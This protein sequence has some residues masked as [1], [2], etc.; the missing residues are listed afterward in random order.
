MD[1]E[2]GKQMILWSFVPRMASSFIQKQYY[3]IRKGG[4]PSPVEAKRQYNLIYVF[5]IL[6]YLLYT[7]VEVE[8]GLPPAHYDFL[9]LPRN[10]DAKDIRSNFRKLSL[11]Y[12]PDKLHAATDEERAQHEVRYLYIQEAYETLKDP[13][14]RTVY[15]KFGQGNMD[16]RRCLTERD[17]IM[18][19]IPSFLTF[20]LGTA[21]VL[22]VFSVMGL[23][24]SGRY[25]RFVTLCALACLEANMVYGNAANSWLQQSLLP[26]RTVNEQVALLHQLY[27]VTCIALSQIGP[28]LF[29]TNKQTSKQ[30]LTELEALTNMQLKE[31]TMAFRSAF[32]PVSRDPHAVTALQRKMEKLAVDLQLLDSDADLRLS[33]GKAHARARAKRND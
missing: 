30:L 9:A 4:A 28:I 7:F 22:T 21:G 23:Q 8:R 17:Y 5:V 18:N 31:S 13:L 14:K 10:A 11:I 25:W 6:A 26:W 12:H 16:C 33:A 20:Y 29:P 1:W 2:F 3:N 15:D 32:E 19:S 24:N 27:V